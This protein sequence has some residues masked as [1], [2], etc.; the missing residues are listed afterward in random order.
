[1]EAHHSQDSSS[2]RSRLLL[3]QITSLKIRTQKAIEEASTHLAPSLAFEYF[4]LINSAYGV[5]GND[6][7]LFR[8]LTLLQAENNLY[9]QIVPKEDPLIQLRWVEGAVCKLETLVKSAAMSMTKDLATNQT[10]DLLKAE[11]SSD[12]TKNWNEIKRQYGVS[13]T[14]FG[15]RINFVSDS[16]KRGIIFRDIEH[17]FLLATYGF[18]KPAVTL[19]GGVIEELLRLYLEYKGISSERNTFESYIQTCEKEGLLKSGISRLSDS[20]RHFRNLVHLNVEKD[21]RYTI[22]QSTAVGAVSSIF[23]IANDF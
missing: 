7:D 18:P 11:E 15:K 10:L 20:V 21:R 12:S 23:T 4:K 22:S 8:E 19:A 9:P 16:F 13:K 5:V 2:R 6:D 14:Q 1:M 17:A 3:E